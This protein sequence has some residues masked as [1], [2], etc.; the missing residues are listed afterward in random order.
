MSSVGNI[1]E[2]SR[3]T[4]SGRVFAPIVH[5]NDNARKKTIEDVEPKKA[6][7]ESSGATL[8]KEVGE[9]GQHHSAKQHFGYK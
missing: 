1:D 9:R 5:R 3:V 4:R 6:T 8:E 7:G 2:T